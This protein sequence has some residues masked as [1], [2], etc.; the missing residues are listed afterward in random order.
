ME[1][2]VT[3]ISELRKLPE[4]ASSGNDVQGLA[5]RLFS[6]MEEWGGQGLAANQI[7]ISRR[8]FVLLLQNAT[9]ICIVNPTITKQKGSQESNEGCLSLPGVIV[10]VKRPHR[11]RVKGFNQYWVPVNYK[12]EGIDAR[13]ACHEIDH[14]D[15]KLIIDYGNG[16]K[17]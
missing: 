1:R 16:F 15:G 9:P 3:D 10:R 11:V 6:A 4:V 7:G 12:F 13:R 17:A 2:I 5:N 14:L 8:I